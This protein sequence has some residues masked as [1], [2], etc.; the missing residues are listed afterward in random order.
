RSAHDHGCDVFRRLTGEDLPS[1]GSNLVRG[2]H[3]YTYRLFCLTSLGRIVTPNGAV[4]FR[5]GGKNVTKRD[6]SNNSHLNNNSRRWIGNRSRQMG[7]WSAANGHEWI[8]DR[9]S[10]RRNAKRDYSYWRVGSNSLRSII[11]IVMCSD[12]HDL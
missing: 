3:G 5:C 10:R 6:G 2:G 1:F 7:N 4:G 9:S 11:Y 12:Q 8:R